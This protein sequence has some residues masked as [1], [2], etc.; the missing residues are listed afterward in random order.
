MLVHARLTTV[1]V[2][3]ITNSIANKLQKSVHALKLCCLQ[4]L[5]RILFHS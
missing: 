4:P 1:T 5:K 2:S 3:T